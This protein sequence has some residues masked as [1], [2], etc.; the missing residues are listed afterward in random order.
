MLRSYQIKVCQ[1][2]CCTDPPFTSK[3]TVQTHVPAVWFMQ[4][5]S[6]SCTSCLVLVPAVWL[7]HQLSGSC[8]SC[9]AHVPAAR[10]MYQLF[11][12]CTSCPAL[13]PAVRLL[14]QLSGSCT[15]CPAPVPAVRL[16][17]QLSLYTASW[18]INARHAV[19][20][21]RLHLEPEKRK[22]ER[23]EERKKERN[24]LILLHRTCSPVEPIG[25]STPSVFCCVCYFSDC[26][27]PRDIFLSNL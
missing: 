15:S 8:T 6:G 9:V 2:V 11:V 27:N 7:M 16:M 18:C 20:L 17:Y 26:V 22:K 10:F 5:L 25:G 21:Q 19:H 12:P 4:Q 3:C 23:K 14:C 1:Q 24:H 13:V